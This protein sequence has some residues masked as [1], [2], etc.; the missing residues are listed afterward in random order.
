MV[1]DVRITVTFGVSGNKGGYD[2][3]FCVSKNILF[4]DLGGD[5]PGIFLVY[6]FSGLS[7]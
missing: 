1:M 4:F 7:I 5:Y 2:E 6:K 3:S